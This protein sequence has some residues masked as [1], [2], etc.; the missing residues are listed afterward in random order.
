MNRREAHTAKPIMR[1]IGKVLLFLALNLLL[2]VLGLYGVLYTVAKGPSPTMRDLFVRSVRETSAMGFLADWFLT[3]AEIDA[4]L[5][6]GK[7][8]EIEDTD[9]SL[10]VIPQPTE[11][12]DTD[13]PFK[14]AWGLVDEDGDGIIIDPVKGEGFVGYMMVVLDPSRVI[15]ASK[16]EDFGSRGYTVAEMVEEFDAVAGINAGGFDDPNGEGNGSIPDTLVVNNGHIYYP[17]NGVQEGFVGFDSNHIMHVGMFTP[18]QIRDKNIQSGVCFGPVLISNGVPREQVFSGINPRTGIGQR[19][20][21]AVLMLVIEGRRVSSLG[22]TYQDMVEI[23]MSYGAVNA[24]NLDGGSSSM[25]WYQGGYI[26]NCASVV[27]IRP[28]PTAFLVLKSED[29]N[30]G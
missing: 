19:S 17:E 14:D 6:Q 4:I 22:A 29:T 2:I 25:M 5:S 3:E 8:V 21:G 7:D 15:M 13:E 9:P 16:P 28:V 10:I 11:P 26:N 18:D 20:D 23:F 1:I 30:N 27:G 12:E 24:C